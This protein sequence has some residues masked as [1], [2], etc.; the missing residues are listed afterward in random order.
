MKTLILGTCYL[1]AGAEGA[2]NYGL[3]LVEL[4]AKVMR[5]VNPDCDIL[6]IDSASPVDPS[7]IDGILVH[8]L[9][10]NVGH[11]NN[12]GMDGWGRSFTIGAMTAFDQKYAHVVYVDADIIMTAPVAPIVQKM[13]R[14]GVKAAIPMC[15]SYH[16]LENGVMFLEA[17]TAY[18][19]VR[20]Y[21][22]EDRKLSP[23]PIDIPEMIT[24]KLLADELF[25]L[26]LRIWR[27]D[28]N[29]LTVN[30]LEHA[31]PYGLPD[32]LTHVRDF[33]VYQRFLELKGIKL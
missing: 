22:W 7:G 5:K 30:N 10:D 19:F 12:G 23:N 9:D 3:R 20:A 16:F 18:D 24:E 33:A 25:T 26:P 6:L 15:M 21:K 28:G 8:R 14:R 31:F 29:V 2:Q 32:G 17:E 4:W 13:A 1:S 27:D 11:L